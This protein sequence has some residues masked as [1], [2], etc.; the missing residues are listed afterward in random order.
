VKAGSK[1]G[2]LFG[3]RGIGRRLNRWGNLPSLPILMT[4]YTMGLGLYYKAPLG[5][6]GVMDLFIGSNPTGHW[7]SVGLCV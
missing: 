5:V 4:A 3:G 2:M 6:I 1:F 7:G